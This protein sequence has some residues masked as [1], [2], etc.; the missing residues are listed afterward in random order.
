MHFF[1]QMKTKDSE[2]EVIF[3]N[4]EKL[5]TFLQKS[6]ASIRDLQD[7][8]HDSYSQSRGMNMLMSDKEVISVHNKKS[9]ILNSYRGEHEAQE[10]GSYSIRVCE[11]GH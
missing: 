10:G 1:K 11:H 4:K 5:V 3:H 8:L 9:N 2:V 7:Q 6:K